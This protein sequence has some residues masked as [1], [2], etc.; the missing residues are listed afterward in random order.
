MLRAFVQFLRETMRFKP[1]RDDK[2]KQVAFGVLGHVHDD[3]SAC[4]VPVYMDTTNDAEAIQVMAAAIGYLAADLPA[5]R[6]ERVIM[7][8][9]ERTA[10]VIEAKA[11]AK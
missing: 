5:G 11:G 10:D 3:G 7:A 6:R 2:P 4:G 9:H 8:A 1:D